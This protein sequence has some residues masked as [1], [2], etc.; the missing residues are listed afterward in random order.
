MVVA[1]NNARL[2]GSRQASIG[3]SPLTYLI[4]TNQLSKMNTRVCKPVMSFIAS[5]VSAVLEWRSYMLV[6]TERPSLHSDPIHF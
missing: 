3:Q 4:D 1:L 2:S 5:W 6:R